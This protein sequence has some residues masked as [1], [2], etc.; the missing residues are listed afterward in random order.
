M[1]RVYV[2]L[3]YNLEILTSVLNPAHTSHSVGSVSPSL[4]VAGVVM[5]PQDLVL[6]W[7]GFTAAQLML[8][9]EAQSL[10]QLTHLQGLFLVS[11]TK[12]LLLI[13]YT[14]LLSVVLISLN[15]C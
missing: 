10:P 5:E 12:F 4:N 8:C 6:V 3:S 11:K 2:L 1:I 13:I 7:R 9:V 15:S 14:I